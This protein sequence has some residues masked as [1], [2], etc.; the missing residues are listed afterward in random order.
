MGGLCGGARAE[1]NS[2][3]YEDSSDEVVGPMQEIDP[4]LWLGNYEA[5]QDLELLKQ[6]RITHICAIGW[7]LEKHHENDIE[8]LINNE[9]Y[10]APEQDMMSVVKPSLEWIDE[11]LAADKKNIVLVHCHKGLS[12]SST[13]AVAYYMRKNKQGFNQALKYVRTKRRVAIPSLG[14][15]FQLAEFEKKN[16]S[17]DLSDYGDH[18]K[19]WEENFEIYLRDVVLKKARDLRVEADKTGEYDDQL[20]YALTCNFYEIVRLKIKHGDVQALK[21]EGIQIVRQMQVD[22]VQDDDTLQRFDHMFGIKKMENAI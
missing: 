9:I 8:Y 3:D 21:D 19:V 11:V 10:D 13:I 1:A 7:D 4:R 14:F 2:S 17:L 12:R 18:E 22:F 6:N 5:A 16:Y 15:E 20:L